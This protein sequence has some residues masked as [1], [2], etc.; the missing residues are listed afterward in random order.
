V[1]A[2][3]GINIAILSRILES[4]INKKNINIPEDINTIKNFRIPFFLS[5]LSPLV[6]LYL[7]GLA[8]KIL[9]PDT[10]HSNNSNNN[11]NQSIVSQKS[12]P[13]TISGLKPYSS[14]KIPKF[15]NNL[16]EISKEKKLNKNILI[17]K[18]RFFI[19]KSPSSQLFY[20]I[21]TN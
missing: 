7:F 15:Q 8:L 17:H 1:T 21:H 16:S 13:F 12:P 18:I 5:I 10:I 3:I 6:E 2:V 9:K 4:C 20:L 19:M 11:L 14:T